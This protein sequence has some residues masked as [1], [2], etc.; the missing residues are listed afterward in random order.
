MFDEFSFSQLPECEQAPEGFRP[1]AE[2][3][4]SQ[5]NAFSDLRLYISQIRDEITNERRKPKRL[6]KQLVCT[7]AFF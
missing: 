7:F 6:D 5:E 1:T 3:Q 4:K 2:W